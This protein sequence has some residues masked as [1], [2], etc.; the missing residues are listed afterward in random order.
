MKNPVTGR[1]YI[2]YERAIQW[3]DGK[4]VR[5]EIAMDITQQKEIEAELRQSHKMEAIGTLAGGIAHEF[6]NVLA[7]ILGNAEMAMDDIP[8]WN[9][10]TRRLRKFVPHH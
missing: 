10:A 2:T 7:I 3:V 4:T 8:E 1:W 5:I 9:P 6:N